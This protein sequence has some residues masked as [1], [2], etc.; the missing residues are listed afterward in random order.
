[1]RC[2]PSRS[3]ARATEGRI[4]A[5]SRPVR[6]LGRDRARP[7]RGGG[8]RAPRGVV[9]AGSRVTSK[10]AARGPSGTSRPRSAATWRRWRTRSWRRAERFDAVVVN[11][12]RRGMSPMAREWVARLEPAG[13]RVRLVRPGHARARSRSLPPPRL[14]HQRAPAARH[15]PAHRRGGDGRRPAAHAHPGAAASSTR[16][17]RFSWSRRGRTSRRRRRAS[18]PGR[19]SR[20]CAGSRARRKPSPSTASTSGRAGSSSSRGVRRLVGRWQDALPSA[21]TRKIY[22]AATRGVTPSKGAITRELR[23]DGKMY[24]AR[25]RYRRLAVASG[26]SVLRVIPEQGR[27]HQ[28][29]APPR[30][31]RPSG[32]RRRP[33]RARPDEP[34]LR[35]EER[36]RPGVPPLRA[37]RDR[38]PR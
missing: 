26:H 2:S 8:E 21:S 7:R 4:A 6:R 24:P 19:S 33:L 35:G 14:R 27:T 18:M 12:P 34:L 3:G 28:N 10:Q 36:P 38:S 29:P 13:D 16:T 20:E 23:E 11:P 30:G 17:A 22:V 32:A 5:D 37:D 9:R 31:H 1:M 15:D 25:T